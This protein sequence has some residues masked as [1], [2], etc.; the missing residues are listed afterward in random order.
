MKFKINL[1]L[2][3]RNFHAKKDQNKKFKSYSFAKY[4]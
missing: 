3:T 2:E 4:S 1:S